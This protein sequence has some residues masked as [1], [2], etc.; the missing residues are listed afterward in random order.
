VLELNRWSA[1]YRDLHAVNERGQ[2]RHE[3]LYFGL[4]LKGFVVSR[5]ERGYLKALVSEGRPTR[6]NTL[7]LL[8]IGRIRPS[9]VKE[10]IKDDGLY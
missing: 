7:G 8:A 5:C 3:R 6:L 2:H 10:E 1:V 9:E 4:S